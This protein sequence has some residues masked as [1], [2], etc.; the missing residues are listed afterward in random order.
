MQGKTVVIT[1][2]N[3]GLGKETAKV[4]AN[5]GA[6]VIMVCRDKVRGEAARQEIIKATNN[7]NISLEICDLA[8]KESIQ[9]CGLSMR[10]KYTAIDVLVNNAGA[11]FG[12]HELNSEG[13]ER[14]FALNV[15]GYF[16]FTHYMLDLLKN[17]A[18]KRIVNVASYAHN[19]AKEIP[20][21]DLQFK[22]NSYRQLN[23]YG[24]S[25]LYD[26]YFTKQLAKIM[27]LQKTGITVNAVHPGTVHSNF[28]KSGT[29][30]FYLGFKIAS[31]F[32]DNVK[33]GAKMAIH[34]AVSPEVKGIN[35]AYYAHM[36]EG[37]LSQLAQ[38]EA[39]AKRL[40]D[41]CMNLAE[42]ET[43]GLVEAI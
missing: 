28:G 2:A 5:K 24:L 20:W 38:S 41:V 13:L 22:T 30:L 40:W 26:I 31:P 25:K 15:M 21:D 19:F 17:G 27:D 37:K 43:Y 9:N 6:T 7:Q 1:G 32:Y 11:I 34:M 23:V 33:K 3:S 18:D 14:T 10:Q 36:K 4:L 35:G 12:T 39:A 16:R 8:S 29:K 42:F